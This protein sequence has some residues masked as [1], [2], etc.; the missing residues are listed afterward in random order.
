MYGIT[1]K[2]YR[3]LWMLLLLALPIAAMA[4]QSPQLMTS[5]SRN[6]IRIGEQLQWVVKLALPNRNFTV[7]WPKLPDSI[8]HF[9][10]I[11][12]GKADTSTDELPVVSQ[13][14]ILTSFDSG[15]WTLPVLTFSFPDSRGDT[16]SLQTR[17]MPVMVSFEPDSTQTLKDIKPIMEA[18]GDSPWLLYLLIAGVVLL[19]LIAGLLL[20]FYFR[21]KPGAA[22][23]VPGINPYDEAMQELDRLALLEPDDPDAIRS[24]HTRLSALLRRYLTRSGKGNVMNKTT[25]D[26]LVGLKVYE[27]PTAVTSDLSAALRCGDAVKFARF[28]PP[29]TVSKQCL[30]QIRKSISDIAAVSKRVSA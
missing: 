4:Q 23:S 8:P 22:A 1:N 20:Y 6:D 11:D 5:I 15:R 17:A 12:A 27:V 24:F 30:E 16:T 9:E 25:S 26:L 2:R 10:L 21:K 3:Y 7:Q 29:V 18:E 14:F 19:L 13:T 28:V